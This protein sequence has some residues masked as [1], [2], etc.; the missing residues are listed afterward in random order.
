MY[1]RTASAAA[2]ALWIPSVCMAGHEKILTI[3]DPAPPVEITHWLKG[4]AVETFE[5]GRIYVLEFWATWCSPCRVNMPHL[6]ELQEQL[7]D[8]DVTIIGVSDEKLQTVVRFLTKADSKNVLWSDKIQYT[9]ATDPDKSTYSSYMRPAGR[10][11]IPTAFV[12]G[13]DTRIEWIG[14]PV[15]IES[16]LTR[17]VRDDW[18][19]DEFKVVYEQKVAPVRQAFLLRDQI[20]AAAGDGNWQAAIDTANRLIAEQPTYD[21]VKVSLYRKMLRQC[22]EPA[23]TYDFGRTIVKAKWD[24]ASTL[25]RIAWSTVDDRDVI[26][27]DLDF[28]MKAARRASELTGGT[29]SSILDTVARVYFEQG[30]LES[31][32]RWQEKAVEHAGDSMMASDLGET[33]IRYRKAAG[34]AD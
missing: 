20:D 26:S 4:D 1:F 18:S 11:T 9:L 5:P 16:V 3:G 32:I 15:E 10:D 13:K 31:A 19:R 24:D 22:T 7:E 33:L 17:V 8:Y 29:N 12:I 27:R 23:L 21:G 25:N 28:A 14:N 34:S 6:S 2:L 30:D